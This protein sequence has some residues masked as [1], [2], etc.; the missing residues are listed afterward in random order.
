MC[1]IYGVCRAKSMDMKF[2]AIISVY[3][4]VNNMDDKTFETI[5]KFEES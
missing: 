2:K 3:K 5:Q 1:S 4:S